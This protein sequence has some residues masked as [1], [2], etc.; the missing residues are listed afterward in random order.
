MSKLGTPKQLVGHRDV[1]RG[2]VYT[3]ICQVELSSGVALVS[4]VN[5]PQKYQNGS[6]PKKKKKKVK[7]GELE[8][9]DF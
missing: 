1:Q 9:L 2:Q 8:D 4:K 5:G 6:Y 7:T 3:W